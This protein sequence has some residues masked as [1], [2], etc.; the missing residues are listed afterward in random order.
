MRLRPPIKEAVQDKAI[1]IPRQGECV[2]KKKK[3]STTSGYSAK[4][5]PALAIK[6][7]HPTII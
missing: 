2:L 1:I 7:C 4:E 3:C 6:G 5:A